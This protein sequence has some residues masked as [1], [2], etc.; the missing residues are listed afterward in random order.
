MSLMQEHFLLQ[1]HLI[2]HAL[3]GL[4][5]RA[6][7]EAQIMVSIVRYLFIRF[8][9]GQVAKL[10]FRTCRDWSH[11]LITSLKWPFWKTGSSDLVT[12]SD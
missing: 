6:I 10:S 12:L 4:Y 5:T 1:K 11:L 9:V 7:S 2:I 3:F 8:L